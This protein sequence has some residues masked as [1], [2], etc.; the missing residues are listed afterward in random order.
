MLAKTTKRNKAK[1]WIVPGATTADMISMKALSVILLGA[2]KEGR[3][4]L[5]NAFAG[6]PSQVVKSA[7]LPSPDE[8]A[9]VLDCECDVLVVDLDRNP[10]PAL[11]V[12]ETA[13]GVNGTMTVM[14]Y[15]HYADR[16]LLVRCMQAGARELLSDPISTADLTGALVRA[17]ARRD[18]L[19]RSRKHVGK[20]LVFVGAKGGSGVTTIASNFA[21]AMAMESTQSVALLDLNIQLGDAAL[22]L[23]LA[24]EFSTLDAL[25]NERRLDSELLSKLMVRHS[26]G[27]KVL[28]APNE[29]NEVQPMEAEVITLV[30]L[31][32]SDFAWVVID[33]GNNYGPFS[34]GLFDLAE[35]V[36]LVAEVSLP[37]LRNS[38]RLITRHFK[39]DARRKLAIVINRFGSRTDDIGEEGV[40]KAMLGAPDWR[41]P[42]DFPA[43][44]RAQSLATALVSND[45]SISR[46][47]IDMARAA[48]GKSTE[49]RKKTFG[50]F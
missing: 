49:I 16:E 36:Y 48:C 47:I 6:T 42:N 24:S 12:V 43:L 37:D 17:S 23:G 38:H 27:V 9:S 30:G 28:A 18:E 4:H 13:F 32:L 14:V 7:P 21:V 2:S 41:V 15:S 5:A 45:N 50:L 26:S 34:A 44:R 3:A 10:E 11:G 35:K 31:L 22:T 8:L 1:D 40:E 29:P 19:T 25:Q 33:A 20:C 39:G 46:V